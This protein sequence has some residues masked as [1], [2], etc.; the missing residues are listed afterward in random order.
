MK[1]LGVILS[2]S[3]L[4]L[5]LLAT[6]QVAFADED[7]SKAINRKDSVLVPQSARFELEGIQDERYQ[8]A[9]RLS[10]KRRFNGT[11]ANPPY[12]DVVHF[13]CFDGDEI[14]VST[15][16]DSRLESR[17]L[18]RLV[19]GRSLSVIATVRF[20]LVRV[21]HDGINISNRLVAYL[22]SFKEVNAEE[23]CVAAQAANF[24]ATDCER[25]KATLGPDYEKEGLAVSL[26]N[27][28]VRSKVTPR[29]SALGIHGIRV[30]NTTSKV[31]TIEIVKVLIEQEGV[32]Q[33]CV[34]SKRTRAPQSWNVDAEDW[35]D[36]HYKDGSSPGTLW[37]FDHS[38]PIVPEK[39]VEVR[40]E[41]K[42]NGGESLILTRIV[43][44]V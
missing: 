39:K 11:S 14:K 28:S 2:Q 24:D 22:E 12:R 1:Y 32:I 16:T 33:P 42:L 21:G 7:E 3:S 13:F 38:E 44:P 8:L 40:L 27:V 26:G 15:F 25:Y 6:G 41:L 5:L 18:K 36:G 17:L 23:I 35:S 30:F 9:G 29:G 34:L 43:D 19:S 37:M 4:V 10:V 31:A 20:E